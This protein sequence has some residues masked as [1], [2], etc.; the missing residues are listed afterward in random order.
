MWAGIEFR[1]CSCGVFGISSVA[2]IEMY[3]A[4]YLWVGSCPV[5]VSCKTWCNV[6]SG[7]LENLF[8][9]L[10]IFWMGFALYN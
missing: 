3:E 7:M 8:V 4:S 10:L 1:T 2:S 9:E 5:E 6:E